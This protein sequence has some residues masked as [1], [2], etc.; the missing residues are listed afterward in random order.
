M[1]HA[2]K[3]LIMSGIAVC[4]SLSGCSILSGDDNN[5]GT[6]GAPTAGT[7][8]NG[9][10][11]NLGKGGASSTSGGNSSSSSGGNTSSTPGQCMAFEGID[12]DKCGSSSVEATIKTVNMMLVID[13]SGS[14]KSGLDGTETGMPSKW[15]GMQTALATALAKVQ[16][17]INFGMVLYPS[18][19]A[20]AAPPNDY[21][22]A[23]QVETG[24]AAVNVPITSGAAAVTAISAALK[25]T[26]PAGGTPTAQ[27]LKAAYDYFVTG[28][29]ALKPGDKYVLLATD[30]GPN[31]NSAN[32]CD[33]QP[34]K[35]T[36]VI[37]SGNAATC[38]NNK[39]FLCLDDSAVLMQIQALADKGIPTF[40]VGVP[41]TEAYATY[42]DAFAVAGGKPNEVGPTKYY[43]VEASG[44][45][46]GLVDVFSTITTQL[47]RNCDIDL[48]SQPDDPDKVNVAIDCN[49]IKRADD[50]WT[51]DVSSMPN[52]LLLKGATCEKIQTSGAKRVDVIYGCP[53]VL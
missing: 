7:S 53:S 12:Q 8:N 18:A 52:K 4:G 29:G 6:S 37:D 51:L 14:M 21:A 17:D 13:K 16:D 49:I 11:V 39:G 1:R 23:C 9:G 27:A 50:T 5:D 38:C 43:K 36:C 30:G 31:C 48:T 19:A 2:V 40:V 25:N 42:L 3:F 47:V 33:N 24:A 35:C 32:T 15:S 46:Q 22:A 44:G 41:G 10:G 28:D 34:D 45:V 26:M 20:A